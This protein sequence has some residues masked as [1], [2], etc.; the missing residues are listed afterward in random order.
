VAKS[1]PPGLP[2]DAR[3]RFWDG[4]RAGS[5]G[6]GGRRCRGGGAGLAGE[7]PAACGDGLED[8]VAGGQEGEFGVGVVAAVVQGAAEAA[9]ELGEDG[10]DGGGALLVEL[11][12]LGVPRRA[13]MSSQLGSM[14]SGARPSRERPVWR[15]SRVTAM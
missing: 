11:P 14:V 1:G 9:G 13:V 8:V 2:R 3:V 7:S 15:A 12:S 4:I 10:L 6:G 5:G